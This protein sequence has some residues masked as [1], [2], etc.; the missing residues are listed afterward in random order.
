MR[1]QVYGHK[2]IYMWVS[3]YVRSR[4]GRLLLE[5]LAE[6]ITH[7]QEIE[8]TTV[9]L[10]IFELYNGANFILIKSAFQIGILFFTSE[11]ALKLNS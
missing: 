8:K 6:N 11:V 9:S 2:N 3:P 4:T 7:D 10:V 5:R 1:K